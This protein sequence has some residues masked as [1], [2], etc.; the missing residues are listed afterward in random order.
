MRKAKKNIVKLGQRLKT[1]SGQ[2]EVVRGDGSKVMKNVWEDHG[3][4]LSRTLAAKEAQRKRPGKKIHIE[5]VRV[6]MTPIE[7]TKPRENTSPSQ[8]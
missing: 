8:E 3:I 4:F 1:L 6:D 2:E 7:G 5:G